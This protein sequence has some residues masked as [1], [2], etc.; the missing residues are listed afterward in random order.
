[1]TVVTVNPGVCGFITTIEVIK[2]EKRKV[3]I[4]I[5]SGC[6]HI[7]GLSNSLKELDMRDVLKPRVECEVHKQ[8]SLHQLHS[9][10]PVPEG[11]IKAIEAEFGLA[12]PRDASI[13]F[14][15]LEHE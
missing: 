5:D 2:Q 14:E 7:A 12:L 11:I 15:T 13:H 8:A 3:S 10:C 6:E 4:R 1:M 9:A